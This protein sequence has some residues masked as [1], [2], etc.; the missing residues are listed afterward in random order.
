MPANATE[1]AKLPVL[2]W[3]YGGFNKVG[4]T[5]YPL[6]D[7]CNL[8]TDAVLVELNY[9][10][11]PM[12]FLSLGNAG[13]QG[14]MAIQDTLAALEWVQTNAAAFG[15]DASKAML[16]GQSAG[17]D[18]TFVISTLPQAPD[19]MI[20]VIAESGGGQFLTPWSVAQDVGAGFAKSVNC[21]TTDVSGGH[22]SPRSAGS[23]P[24]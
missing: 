9:R 5:S 13:I 19:L 8:A 23:L 16:F 10:V 24:Q 22:L 18:N 2:V 17:A 7:G 1:G 6:Y 3:A 20:G 14:N 12:G 4:G 15:G 11:G 21:S